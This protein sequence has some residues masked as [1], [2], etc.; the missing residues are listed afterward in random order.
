V[1]VAT[2]GDG[3]GTGTGTKNYEAG[4]IYTVVVRGIANS[5]DP[6]LQTKATLIQHN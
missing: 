2:V 5:L 1:P 3:T 4:R 6:N